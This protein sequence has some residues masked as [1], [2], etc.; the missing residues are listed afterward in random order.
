MQLIANTVCWILGFLSQFQSVLYCRA[1]F[2]P[3]I[4]RLT[5]ITKST[6][7]CLS[8]RQCDRKTYLHQLECSLTDRWNSNQSHWKIFRSE[9][10]Y[11]YR[12]K[13]FCKNPLICMIQR[14]LTFKNDTSDGFSDDWGGGVLADLE[15]DT[16]STVSP[17]KWSSVELTLITFKCSC[18]TIKFSQLV[19]QI[20]SCLLNGLRRPV[21]FY[22]FTWVKSS[23]SLPRCLQCVESLSPSSP[24]SASVSQT[25]S[26][27]RMTEQKYDTFYIDQH[28]YFW[29]YRI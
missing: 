22:S 2:F 3:P 26:L 12:G 8:S 21:T 10:H 29:Y 19:V 16:D 11:C 20:F 14:Y 9:L 18:K 27:V 1:V 24:C 6:W 7:L 17:C 28:R 4:P 5:H 15:K 25:H 23:L 13:P